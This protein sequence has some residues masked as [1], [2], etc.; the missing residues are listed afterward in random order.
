MRTPAPPTTSYTDSSSESSTSPSTLFASPEPISVYKSSTLRIPN[1]DEHTGITNQDVAPRDSFCHQQ[2]L[3]SSASMPS[4]SKLEPLNLSSFSASTSAVE[5]YQLT[6]TAK[7]VVEDADH[8]AAPVNSHL[9]SVYASDMFEPFFTSIF[10]PSPSIPLSEDWDWTGLAKHTD[11]FSS[12]SQP[13]L[14]GAPAIET[15]ENGQVLDGL[16]DMASFDA[17][18]LVIG[19][20][21]SSSIVEADPLEP[22]L[23]HY[24]YLFFNAFLSQIPIVHATTFISEQKP[25]VLLGAMQAC[26]ALFVKTR[27][28]SIFINKTLASA[29]EALV[30]EFAKNPTDSSDQIHLI[31]AVVLLQTIGL[32]HQLPD[33]RASSSIYHGML[34]MMIR[35]TGMILKNVAWVPTNLSEI[36]LESLWQNWVTHETTKRIY[37]ALPSS[38]HPSEIELNLPCEDALWRA[39][40]ATD[41]LAVLQQPSPY[42]TFKSRLTGVHMLQTLGALSETRLLEVY[43]PIN[44]FS[45]FI[46]IHA[47]L[48]HLFVTCVEGRLPKGDTISTV[49][50]NDAVNQE[51][52]RLQYALHNWLQSWLNA[53][54]LPKVNDVNEEPP[55]IYNGQ[56]LPFIRSGIETDLTISP[57]ILLAWASLP[58][59]LPRGFTAI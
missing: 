42:G 14:A 5:L 39:T 49:S 46:L 24:L 37:F 56:R 48:R 57:S 13:T 31:L 30:S 28:A 26:G 2:S 41:W 18:R 10:T 51:I 4:F 16:V 9:S 50:T 52:F 21:R 12:I 17:P 6:S 15:Y 36:S 20:T 19:D 33:Q 7:D 45:H 22:E 54:E 34:V 59:S 3:V 44:P 38:Y 25:P 8:D 32:F 43:V 11:I 53:P 35:R 23:E 1:S 40:C 55:F 47:M 29:R 58:S 27:K